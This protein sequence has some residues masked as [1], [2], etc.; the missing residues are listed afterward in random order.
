MKYYVFPIGTI[1]IEVVTKD[2]FDR[3][4]QEGLS[5]GHTHVQIKC[6]GYCDK[7]LPIDSAALDNI[8]ANIEGHGVYAVK[9]GYP[10]YSNCNKFRYDPYVSGVTERENSS[11]GAGLADFIN[12]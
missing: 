5:K 3:V 12:S 6:V 7:F 8:A 2:E 9:T 4:I 10:V 11:Y 1:D